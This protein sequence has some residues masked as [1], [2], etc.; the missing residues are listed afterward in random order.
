MGPRRIIGISFKPSEGLPSVLLKAAGDNVAPILAA[1]RAH[2][3]IPIHQDAAL[4]ESLYRVPIE[5]PIGRE[6]FPV[7][8]VILAQV[9]DLDQRT[10][11]VEVPR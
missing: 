3:E 2:G 8:A 10:T 5:A 6:L 7:M 9:L 4:A 1:A 11:T